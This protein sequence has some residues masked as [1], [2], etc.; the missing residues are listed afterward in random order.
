MENATRAL[1]MAASVLI[2]LVIISAI[3]LVFNN[4]LLSSSIS[5]LYLMLISFNSFS[6]FIIF[7]IIQL[8]FQE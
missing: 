1:T 3:L 4:W 2:A 6:F 7:Y 8:L 5:F